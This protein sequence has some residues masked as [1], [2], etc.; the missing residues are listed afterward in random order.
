MGAAICTALALGVYPDRSSAIEH[1]VRIQDNF[2]P[3]EANVVLYERINQ[4][5]YTKINAATEEV[6]QASHRIFHD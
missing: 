1:M 5:V 4:E 6:L 3:D 2:N